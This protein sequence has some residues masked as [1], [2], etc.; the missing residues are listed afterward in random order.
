MTQFLIRFK[1]EIFTK[2][3]IAFFAMA[4]FSIISCNSNFTAKPQGYF[5]IRFAEA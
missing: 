2:C 1:K 5:T 4:I 3:L